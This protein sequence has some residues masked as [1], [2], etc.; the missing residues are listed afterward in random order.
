MADAVTGSPLRTAPLHTQPPHAAARAPAQHCPLGV[1]AG[2]VAAAGPAAGA[3]GGGRRHEEGDAEVGQRNVHMDQ[4][5][6]HGLL[7]G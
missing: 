2:Q 7:Q 3:S 4:P 6:L 5:L 1:Q